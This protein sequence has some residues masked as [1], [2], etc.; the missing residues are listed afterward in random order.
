MRMHF[1]NEK[2]D[3]KFGGDSL[4]QYLWMKDRTD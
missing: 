4:R 3:G 2:L 1:N